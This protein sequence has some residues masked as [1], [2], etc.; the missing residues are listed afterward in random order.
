MNWRAAEV[1]VRVRWQALREADTR[2]SRSQAFAAYATALDAEEAAAS[3]L[4][5]LSSY[6]IAA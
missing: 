5:S 4:A 3:E 1:L 2:G 6:D